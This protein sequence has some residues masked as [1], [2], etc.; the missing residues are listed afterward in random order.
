V[1]VALALALT[2][3]V[4]VVVKKTED[5]FTPRLH[6]TTWPGTTRRP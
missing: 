4:V 5:P 6:T 3:V 1:A 2:V